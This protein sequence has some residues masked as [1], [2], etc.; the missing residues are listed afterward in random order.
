MAL[1]VN[2]DNN[3]VKNIIMSDDGRGRD[4]TIPAILISKDDGKKIEDFYIKNKDNKKIIDHIVLEIDFEMEHPNNTVVFNLYFSSDSEEVYRMIEELYPYL[5][6]LEASI[7]ANIHYVTY[8]TPQ[9]DKDQITGIYQNCLGSGKY[10]NSPGK[11][12]TNN[13]RL[14]VNEN[15]KQKCLYK[16]AQNNNNMMLYWDYM[17]NFFNLCLDIDDPKFNP[18]CSAIA[19]LQLNIPN[20]QINKCISDSFINQDKI[21]DK[22]NLSIYVLNKLLEEDNKSKRDYYI[23][24][25]PA[26]TINGR[27]FWGSWKGENVFEA[28]CAGYKKKPEICYAEGAFIR[29]E[30][31]SWVV[32][33]ILIILIL[34][35]NLLIFYFCRNYMR[36]RIKERMDSNEINTKIN[37]VVSSYLALREKK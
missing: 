36:K 13:G 23:D 19:S 24:F 31:M 18:E 14:I 35:V 10:C 28:I 27:H 34:F 29:P 2:N 15:I 4:L 20:D 33:T 11:F 5:E 9:Y 25:L 22:E 30:G 32:I 3:D 26:I 12:N 21:I 37:E 7:I 1:I 16:W 8:Q 17:I 6:K